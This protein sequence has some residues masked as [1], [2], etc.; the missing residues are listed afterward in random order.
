MSLF[1]LR[2]FPILAHVK[3][4]PRRQAGAVER[5]RCPRAVLQTA[6][7]QLRA[8]ASQHY[9]DWGA[10]CSLDWDRSRAGNTRTNCV[11][12]CP[13]KGDRYRSAL[14][15]VP[16]SMAWSWALGRRSPLGQNRGGTPI[17]VRIP[18]D[19]RPRQQRGTRSTASV[20]VPLPFSFVAWVGRNERSG[21]QKAGTTPSFS[22]ARIF[23]AL[24]SWRCLQ[25]LGGI[26]AARTASLI[27]SLR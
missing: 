11:R 22:V 18:M 23:F 21:Q 5:G 17:D 9:R 14:R 6:P 10:R 25:K 13:R 12:C 16:G 24:Q 26:C 27:P 1:W 20:G 8:S 15:H 3:D 19:A 7:G 4:L 2:S